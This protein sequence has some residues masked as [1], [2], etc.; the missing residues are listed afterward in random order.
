[1]EKKLIIFVLAVC[2]GMQFGVSFGMTY[3]PKSI[4]NYFSAQKEPEVTKRSIFYVFDVE[5]SLEGNISRREAIR[6]VKKYITG[7]FRN[8][9]Q[10][11]TPLSKIRVLQEKISILPGGLSYND[12]VFTLACDELI[13]ETKELSEKRS[14]Q[15]EEKDRLIDEAIDKFNKQFVTS[16][17]K[18]TTAIEALLFRLTTDARALLSIALQEEFRSEDIKFFGKEKHAAMMEEAKVR[19]S[20]NEERK[21][22]FEERKKLLADKMKEEAFQQR[23]KQVEAQ[24]QKNE[25]SKVMKRSSVSSVWE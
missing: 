2:I 10:Y 5:D 25:S 23:K 3:L 11:P 19:V 21:Q 22:S 8:Q 4:R 7:L 15:E 16:T 12:V 13:K 1:M 9:L 24:L 18:F 6:L 17:D 14:E 20:M